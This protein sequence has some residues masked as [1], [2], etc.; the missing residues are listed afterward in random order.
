M[1]QRVEVVN[2]NTIR[3]TKTVVEEIDTENLKTQRE[4]L[5][6]MVQNCDNEK[7]M[8]QQKIADINDLLV[9]VE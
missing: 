4:D 1:A 6:R 9:Q 8:F 2:G 5:T 3:I 7:L